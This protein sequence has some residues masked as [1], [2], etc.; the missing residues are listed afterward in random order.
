[1]KRDTVYIIG[2]GFSAGLGYPLTFDLLV[3]LWEQLDDSLKDDLAKVIKFHHTSFDAKSFT[4]FPNV[5]VLLSKIHVNLELF[6]ASRVEVGG[7]KKE[8]LEEIRQGILSQTAFWF[9]DLS[10]SVDPNKTS[11][12]WL[13]RFRQKL[14]SENA[15]IISFN[16]DLVLEKLLFDK[17]L[18]GQS[19]GF[20]PLADGPILLKPHGSL[21]WFDASQAKYITQDRRVPIFGEN[22]DAVYAFLRYRAPISKREREYTPLIIPPIYLK[23][24]GKPVFQALWKSAM[25]YL[26][27]AKNV[28]FLGYSMPEFDLHA[29]FVM[30]CGFYNQV[31]GQPRKKGGR[32]TATGLAHVA[33]VNPDQAAA[34]RIEAIVGEKCDWIPAPVAQWMSKNK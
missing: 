29:Q 31:Y 9:H 22:R 6:D 15:V 18:D 26:S 25:S 4:S 10:K 33:I 3:R 5:E 24:F 8:K 17:E 2:A 1:M 11:Q 12:K 27:T 13:K 14:I 32:T 7:F 21:N 28:F 23:D 19:Y 20:A 34:L 30:R 16:W